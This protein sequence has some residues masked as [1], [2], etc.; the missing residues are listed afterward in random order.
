MPVKR[1]APLTFSLLAVIAAL[2]GWNWYLHREVAA[3][4]ERV[5]RVSDE[6][7]IVRQRAV[8]AEARL[9]AAERAAPVVTPVTAAAVEKAPAG[10][11]PG[12]PPGGFLDNPAVQNAMAAAT[13]NALA[14]R[15]GALFRKLKLGPQELER[16]KA[17]LTE[18]QLG[19][20][21][22]LRAAQGQGL[23]N[24][25][26][27]VLL[28]QAGGDSDASIRALLGEPGYAA[29]E[30]Y[31]D[32]IGSYGLLDQVER[33]LGVTST[34]L[35]AT[36]SEAVLKIIRE[37]ATTPLPP[38][39][40]GDPMFRVMQGVGGGPAM[41]AVLSQPQITDRTIEVAKT[42][43][44]PAQVNVLHQMQADQKAQLDAF[45][46]MRGGATAP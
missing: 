42:V 20:M 33:Q 24:D 18:R 21:D 43:L 46:A 30:D 45:R 15:Y 12:R 3:G 40:T 2:A 34:P 17:L 14:Q 29:F 28:D 39:G 9:A 13:R 1:S 38:G 22:T 16:L 10:A 35:S 8:G 5:R 31:E 37:T 11:V 4:A 25:A 44:E 19:A 27:N 7:A 41:L 36:Q 26:I 6:L 23:S 32:N